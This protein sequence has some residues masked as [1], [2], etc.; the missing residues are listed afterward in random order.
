M[1][2]KT[3]AK[4]KFYNFNVI[5]N[6]VTN[7]INIKIKNKKQDFI[8]EFIEY[9]RKKGF[10][11][12][13]D[14]NTHIAKY[15]ELSIVL[16]NEEDTTFSFEIP[17]EKISC[18]IEELQ[19]LIKKIEENTNHYQKILDYFSIINYIYSIDE[20]PDIKCTTVNTLFESYINENN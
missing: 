3:I 13:I 12:E 16:I 8:N 18:K 2:L 19:G 6:K 1:K 4:Y 15:K 17:S 14:N 11:M 10:N 7:N 5:C 9:F 20:L